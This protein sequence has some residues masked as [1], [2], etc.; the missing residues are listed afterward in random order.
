MARKVPPLSVIEPDPD[1]P[2]VESG[3][4]LV[5]ADTVGCL[6]ADADQLGG[7]AVLGDGHVDLSGEVLQAGRRL[8]VDVGHDVAQP[9]SDRLVHWSYHQHL[10]LVNRWGRKP[11]ALRRGPST[12]SSRAETLSSVCCECQTRPVMTQGL[13]ARPGGARVPDRSAGDGIG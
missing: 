3:I 4:L 8:S 12:V 10:P 9:G 5:E 13:S 2:A 1:V 6:T 11:P 7:R